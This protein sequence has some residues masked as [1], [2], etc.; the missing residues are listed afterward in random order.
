MT[1]L[2]VI[3]G[4]M[5]FHSHSLNVNTVFMAEDVGL[6]THYR[7]HK[8]KIV[9]FLSAMRHHAESISSSFEVLYHE[10][11]DEPFFSRLKKVVQT[12]E[13]ST[14]VTYVIADDFFR[15]EFISFCHHMNIS[16]EF[17]RN[18]SFLTSPQEFASWRSGRSQLLLHDFYVWQRKRLGVL[19][20]SEG[21][22]VG[23]SW[24]FDA[25]NRKK[26][27]ND[28]IPA[29]LPDV[30]P[31]E[32]TKEVISLVEKRFSSHPGEASSFWLPVTHTDAVSW[33]HD[34]FER[35]FSLFGDFQDSLTDEYPFVFHSVLSPLINCGLLTPREVLDAALTYSA[36][37][38]SVE[39]F[40][41]QLI[42]WREFI[43]Y[44]YTDNPF[45]RNV[46][47]HSNKLSSVWWEGGSGFDPLDYMVSKINR[48]GYAHHIE[49]LMVAG[50][51]MLLARI[52][53]QDS[54]RWFMEFFVDSADWVMA[55]NVFGMG[56]F[57]DGGVFAT[58]PYISGSNYI[59]K[60][61]FFRGDWEEL[62]DGLYW[63]FILDHKSFFLNNP[64]M[65]M[66]LSLADKMSDEKIALHRQSAAAAL[67]ILT[68]QE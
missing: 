38:N 41:R 8:H 4:D 28:I 37:L 9:L 25:Q 58:K 61:G 53:P 35:R 15:D 18:P 13:V 57:S 39:G 42:G 16:Y 46:F 56:L 31:D 32:I 36:P 54:Y 51:L 44:V 5:L 19:L 34:F 17:V 65:R 14:L 20:D 63:T 64:R 22:P 23:G 45:E 49:R 12:R 52:D 7:Y 29:S 55:P 6:C 21:S 48:F 59:R 10:L 50:N 68:K 40:V 1:R 11:S 3:L 24:S 66:I 60:M 27:P 33:M 62:W 67:K 43:R 26:L 47:G 2:G 30:S